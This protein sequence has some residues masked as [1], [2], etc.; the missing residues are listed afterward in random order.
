MDTAQV[1]VTH[2]EIPIIYDEREDKWCFTLRGRDRSAESLAKAKGIIDKPVPTEK[3]KPFQHIPAWDFGYNDLPKRVKVTG[4]GEGRY[5]HQKLSVWITDGK[6]RRKENAAF[7][8]YPS[9]E[10]N[11]AIAEQVIRKMKEIEV[12][13][14][15]CS[16]LK[17]KLLPLVIEPEE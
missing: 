5:S 12:L 11:D 7:R 16:N 15:E 6:Q 8:V 2:R 3:A 17:Q 9:N 4:I 14:E 1:Q 10:T 13:R